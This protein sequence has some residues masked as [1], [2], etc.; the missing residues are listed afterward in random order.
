MKNTPPAEKDPWTECMLRGEFARAW[1]ISDAAL[2]ERKGVPCWHWPR[3]F[4]YLWDGTPLAGKRVL[5]R[6]YHGLGDT[7]QFARFLAPLR[8]IAREVIVWAQPTLI[9]L[10]ENVAGVD[11][12][13]PL[14][15]GVPEVACDV[16][17]EIMELAH[18]FRVTPDMLSARVPYLSAGSAEWV[19]TRLGPDELAVGL[20][21]RAGDWDLRRS[22]K[23]EQL[24]PLSR[25]RGVRWFSLQETSEPELR[26]AE[27]GPVVPVTKLTEAV[28]AMDL[29]ITV[30]SLAAHLAGALGVQTWTLLPREPDWRWM[31]DREDS[32]WYP[33]MRL[34]RQRR[35]G[36]WAD[37]VKR[38][39]AE[40]SVMT[41][42]GEG[43]AERERVQ[44]LGPAR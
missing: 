19:R 44:S 36:D 38:V 26:W 28:C 11:L 41:A 42:R 27:D 7:I 23:L 14:H 39:A 22:L 17:V 43:T 16:D 31:R 20:V 37:V 2:R 1:A 15:D 25:V 34:W 13:L 35:D 8:Q 6:C 5:V 4:Q 10:L 24:E 18:V 30:D 21:W 9:P 40:L 12:V 32:P 33:T 29:V 3:H